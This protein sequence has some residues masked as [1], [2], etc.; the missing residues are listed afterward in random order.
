MC[1]GRKLYTSKHRG[2]E[3]MVNVIVVRSGYRLYQEDGTDR[4]LEVK[5]GQA[6][7]SATSIYVTENDYTKT[8]G[9]TNGNS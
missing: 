6:V 7:H 9:I 1:R 2:A 5:D 3:N 4:F 8:K